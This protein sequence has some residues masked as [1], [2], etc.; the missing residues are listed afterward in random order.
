MQ[1]PADVETWDAERVVAFVLERFPGRVALA[2]SFQKEETVL[3]DI[4]LALEPRARIFAID[5]HHLFPET[6]A[7]WRQV[8]ER[9]LRTPALL[10]TALLGTLSLLSFALIG[11]AKLA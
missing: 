6:Y 8:E 9:A 10:V 1:L 7:Y 11:L 3:L 4:L 5:T 2:C